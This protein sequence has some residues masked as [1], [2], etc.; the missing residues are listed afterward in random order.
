MSQTSHLKALK[1]K[2][3]NLD[4]QITQLRRHPSADPFE[5]QQL[6]TRKLRVKDEIASI[7]QTLH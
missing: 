1:V 4:D 3:S 2:H 5:I 6:K 7:E